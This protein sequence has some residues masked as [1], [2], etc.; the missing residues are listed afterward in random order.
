MVWFV[1]NSKEVPANS[2]L[3]EPLALRFSEA[4]RSNFMAQSLM[5][6]IVWSS[7]R[8]NVSCLA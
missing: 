8:S 6:I 3:G 5:T 2:A 4:H 1:N 7:N